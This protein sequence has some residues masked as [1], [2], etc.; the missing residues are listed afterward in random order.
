MDVDRKSF[1][2]LAYPLAGLFWGICQSMHLQQVKAEL[3]ETPTKQVLKVGK[4]E[5]EMWKRGILG[6]ETSKVL[7]LNPGSSHFLQ[8]NCSLFYLLIFT[9]F[10][11]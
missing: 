10:T 5:K 3:N 1:S 9:H 8:I 2:D 11:L 6:R 4:E 7:H